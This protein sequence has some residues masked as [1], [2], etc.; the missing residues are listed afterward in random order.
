MVGL[1]TR[2][3]ISRFVVD[4]ASVENT[5]KPLTQQ[6]KANPITTHF[7]ILLRYISGKMQL[8]V[9]LIYLYTLL[10]EP[11]PVV[12]SDVMRVT[13]ILSGETSGY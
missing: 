11:T 4:L 8:H 2:L 13:C 9:V 7:N 10:L 12:D 6:R 3:V 5:S 1:G